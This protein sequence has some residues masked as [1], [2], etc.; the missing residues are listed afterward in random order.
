MHPMAF[1]SCKLNDMEMCY[2]VQENEMTAIVHY[3]RT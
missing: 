1:E 3:L 2:T